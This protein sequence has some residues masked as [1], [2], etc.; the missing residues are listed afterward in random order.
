MWKIAVQSYSLRR[1]IAQQ[2]NVEGENRRYPLGYRLCPAH[3]YYVLNFDREEPR[4]YFL[5]DSHRSR[6]SVPHKQITNGNISNHAITA[7]LIKQQEW[8]LAAEMQQNA[9]SDLQPLL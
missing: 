9:Q 3:C 1:R 7:R 6:T 4:F 2:F 5:A 8:G